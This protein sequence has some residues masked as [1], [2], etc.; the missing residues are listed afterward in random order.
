MTIRQVID[1]LT[2]IFNVISEFFGPIFEGMFGGAEEGEEGDDTAA[3][4]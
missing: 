4:A 1:L 2:R 3:E